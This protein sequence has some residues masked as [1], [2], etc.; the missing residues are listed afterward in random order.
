MSANIINQES[1]LPTSETKSSNIN[2]LVRF[3]PPLFYIVA[4]VT[5]ILSI[6]YPYWGMV[7]LAPQYP[8]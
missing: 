8:G 3:I 7:L 4:A 1:T 5:I 2:K 6:S